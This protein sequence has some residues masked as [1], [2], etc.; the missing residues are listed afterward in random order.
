MKPNRNDVVALASSLMSVVASIHRASQK[1]DAASLGILG[2]VAARPRVRPSDVAHHLGVNQSSVTR[3]MQK[4]ERHGLVKLAADPSDGRS[5]HIVLTIAGRA[6]MRRLT[7]IGLDRFALFVKDWDARDVRTL[8][9]LLENFERSKSAA[10]SA[11]RPA[12]PSW[13]TRAA[14]PS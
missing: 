12:S 14:E 11:N 9:R 10:G 13:R 4:L 1:G 6:E 2:L 3:Q 8:A 5:C 7:S